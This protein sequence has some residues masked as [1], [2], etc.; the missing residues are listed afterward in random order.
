MAALLDFAQSSG[1]GGIISSAI[2]AVSNAIG[3]KRQYERQ[4]KLMKAQQEYQT[5][6]REAS[7][8]WQHQMW[9]LQNEYNTPKAQMLRMKAAGLNPDM[10]YGTPNTGTIASQIPSSTNGGAPS[11]P[12]PA[13]E[14]SSIAAAEHVGDAFLKASQ[15][16]LNNANARKADDDV[17]TGA[18]LR[19]KMETEIALNEDLVKNTTPL[20]RQELQARIS[21]LEQSTEES[22]VRLDNLVK[23]GDILTLN[24]QELEKRLSVMDQ[25]L[26]LEI[27]RMIATNRQAFADAGIK[28]ETLKYFAEDYSASIKLKILQSLSLTQDIDRKIMEN[29]SLSEDLSSKRVV[30]NLGGLQG[31]YYDLMTSFVLGD[32]SIAMQKLSAELEH[33]KNFSGA[34]GV[35]DIINSLLTGI[36]AALG[37]IV[38]VAIGTK[39]K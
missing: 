26:T 20:Q 31:N 32:R 12:T 15:I 35:V 8:K 38:S 34:Q 7:Q 11:V 1:G 36:G 13:G 37:T 17:K 2:G 16:G 21:N 22:R 25:Q 19:T 39:K 5:S 18:V 14:A 33:Y 3:A 27:E 4:K 9:N 6:E 30:R 29:E 10:M 24:K 23:Q 28:E